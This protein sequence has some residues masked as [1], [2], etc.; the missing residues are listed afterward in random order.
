M[1]ADKQYSNGQPV[2]VQDGDTLTYF[3][4]TGIVKARGKNIRE[5][6]EGQWIFNRESG[7]LWQVGN[8]LNGKKHGNWTRYDE[9]AEIEYD[10]DFK[11]GKLIR[12]NK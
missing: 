1:K 6:M 2:C 10:A 9:N 4:K 12:K 7:T 5:L 3:F 11:D 8:F